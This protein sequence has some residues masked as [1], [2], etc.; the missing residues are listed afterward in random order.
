MKRKFKTIQ[1]LDFSFLFTNFPL[2]YLCK[3][4]YNTAKKSWKLCFQD[5]LKQGMRESNSHQRFWR[6]LSYHLTN[7]IIL[8]IRSNLLGKQG[9]WHATCHFGKQGIGAHTAL[10]CQ[11]LV[12][13][14][15]QAPIKIFNFEQRSSS[16]FL[17]NLIQKS[18]FCFRGF[19]EL[20]PL[21]SCDGGY[22][23]RLACYITQFHDFSF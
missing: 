16:L 5:F 17:K 4:Y 7:F 2:Y 13:E 1:F 3:Y 14:Y 20:C 10:F 11:K 19:R 18:S 8:T 21:T 6:P 15:P 12:G 23:P 22:P 9:I